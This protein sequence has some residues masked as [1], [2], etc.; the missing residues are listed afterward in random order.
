MSYL[1]LGGEIGER[2]QLGCHERSEEIFLQ[3]LMNES[4]AMRKTIRRKRQRR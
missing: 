3:S 2:K 1:L 4:S